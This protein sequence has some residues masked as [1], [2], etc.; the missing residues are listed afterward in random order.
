MKQSS[1]IGYNDSNVLKDIEIIKNARVMK[2]VDMQDLKSCGH[3]SVR[4]RFPP[5]V[6]KKKI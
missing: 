3:L 4:V 6:P 2:P 1:G 5:R